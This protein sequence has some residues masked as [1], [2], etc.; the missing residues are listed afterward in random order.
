MLPENHYCSQVDLLKEL[1]KK[2]NDMNILIAVYNEQL[3]Q[4]MERSN[5]LEAIVQNVEKR[6]YN[7]SIQLYIL[8][9]MA[10]VINAVVLLMIRGGL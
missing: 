1:I 2:Q 7:L 3:K 10:T 6:S 8:V 9:G 5:R 4:H